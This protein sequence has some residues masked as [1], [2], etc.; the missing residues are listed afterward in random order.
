MPQTNLTNHENFR[1]DP[2]HALRLIR[3]L[4]DETDG[5]DLE[6]L[7]AEIGAVARMVLE[8]EPDFNAVLFGVEK[9][10]RPVQEEPPAF[11]GAE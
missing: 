4:C 8:H 3:K 11:D 9:P 10:E 1:T 6:G 5:D 2:V 7:V